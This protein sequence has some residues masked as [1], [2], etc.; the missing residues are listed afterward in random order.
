MLFVG[1]KA[2]PLFLGTNEQHGYENGLTHE[3][4]EPACFDKES[5]TLIDYHR[6]IPALLY[7]KEHVIDGLPGYH[8]ALLI[9]S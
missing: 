7:G 2:V 6:Y 1:V 8:L 4:S 5:T 9:S 3:K